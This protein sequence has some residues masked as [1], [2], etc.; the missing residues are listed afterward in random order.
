MEYIK[1]KFKDVAF[2]LKVTVKIKRENQSPQSKW[3][4]LYSS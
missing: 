2:F 3:P 4:H 1:F